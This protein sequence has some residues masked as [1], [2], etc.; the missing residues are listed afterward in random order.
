MSVLGTT[1]SFTHQM[2]YH[3]LYCP[4][5][6]HSIDSTL[7]RSVFIDDWAPFT[8]C[9]WKKSAWPFNIRHS[10]S[11]KDVQTGSNALDYFFIS[12]V[13]PP[14]CQYFMM[15]YCQKAT[16]TS[17]QGIDKLW[18]KWFWWM[19]QFG[20]DSQLEPVPNLNRYSYSS[21]HVPWVKRLF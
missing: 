18:G 7:T 8:K 20:S 4:R 17:I 16:Q 19:T 9:K 3:H 1:A 21:H 11:L 6:S 15:H 12:A 13:T 5:G 2:I 10:P 14:L